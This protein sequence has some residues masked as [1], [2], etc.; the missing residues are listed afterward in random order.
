MKSKIKKICLGLLAICIVIVASVGMIL[1]H[2]ISTLMSIEQIRTRDDDHLDGSVYTMDVSG[3]FYL[4][5]FIAQG[6]VKNDQELIDFLVEHLTHGLVDIEVKKPNIGCSSF[7]AVSEGGDKLFG[8]NYDFSKTNT[9]IVRTHGKGERHSTLSTVDLQFMDID[10]N[11]DLTDIRDKVISM[12]APYTP[13]DG[14]NDAGLSCG[15]YMTYQGMETVATDQNTSRPDI[16]STTLLR[17]MLDYASTVEE[18]VEI[19][20]KFD[21][22]DSANTSFH[23]MI[24]DASGKSAILEWVGKTDATDNDGSKRE[25][26][27]TYNDK[28]AH[29]GEREGRTD[30][31]VIT[32]FIIQPGYYD[33]MS[34]KKTG[35]DRYEKIYEELDDRN[36]IVKDEKDAMSILQAVG[37]RTWKNDDKN[38]CTVHSVVYNNTDCTMLWVPNEN[39]DDPDAYF[40]FGF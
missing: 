21:L 29:I 26:V 10:G 15:I 3:D 16:T 37:R 4:E 33:E 38:G 6:G 22:H 40:E 1:R 23:Y 32:N 35:L 30:Y 8:R 18:A 34:S 20:K 28:D 19:A 13:I 12:A 5:D 25:L 7:T 9:M 36:G 31:Q 2:E 11:Q 17:L 39:F 27:V 14:I 24:A